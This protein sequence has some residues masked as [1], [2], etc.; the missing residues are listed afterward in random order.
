MALAI[1]NISVWRHLLLAMPLC[2]MGNATAAP[3]PISLASADLWKPVQVPFSFRYGG[4][5]SRSLL[6][7]W[8][9]SHEMVNE[10]QRYVYSD[11]QTGLTVTVDV[12]LYPEFPG[13]LDWVIHFANHG[14]RDTPILEDILPLDWSVPSVSA[15]CVVRHARGS[16]ARATDFEPLEERV[17]AEQPDHIESSSGDSSNV[18]SLPFFNL[19]CGD[20]GFIE[21]IAWTGNWKADFQSAAGAKRLT[22]KSGMKKTH[23]LLHPGEEI[24]TPRIVLQS[25]SGGDWQDAQ[26]RWR[27]LVLAHYTPQADGKPMQGPILFGDWGGTPIADKIAYVQWVHDHEIPAEVYAVDAGWYGNSF[28]AENDPTNPWW[29]N[30]GDWYPNPRYYP[31]GLAPLGE[32][33]K[34]AGFGFS[35]WLEPE[36]AMAGSGLVAD[37]PDRFLHVNQPTFTD[38]RFKS[39]GAFLLDLGN[40]AARKVITTMVSQIIDESKMTWYRQDFNVPPERYWQGADS[41]DRVGMAETRHIEGLY[42]MLDTLLAKHPGL[43]IDN[44]ASGGRRLDLEMMS[45]SFVIWRTDYGFSDPLADL[46]QTQGLAPWVPTNMGFEPYTN[47]KPWNQPGPFSTPTNLYLMRLGYNAGYGTAPGAA[48]VHNDA[49]VAWIK[50]ALSEYQQVRPYFYGDFY[51]LA[52]YSLRSDTWTVWQWDRPEQDDGI[53][54]VFRRNGDQQNSK[55]L[56]LRHLIANAFYQ[57][58]IRNSCQ[59]TSSK[60]ISGRDLA[61][62]EVTLPDVPDSALVLY[63]KTPRTD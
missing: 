58:E 49:W 45:R 22:M 17:T 2:L 53:V 31:N 1:A 40:P 37:H 63:S 62:L 60:T 30:R 3:S 20:R 35:L 12:R 52:P 41:P 38:E 50:E 28:G 26:N 47:A 4:V 23:L 56:H 59:K 44:C 19:Q 27:R 9:S 13:S 11:P 29:K 16:Q 39:P 51:P 21:A 32:A 48:G 7:K 8:N 6:S 43:R 61:N 57:V 33:I 14:R 54:L 10:G 18:Q 46:A 15:G 25:W 36:T 24:R 5:D 55:V 42:Q 34:A